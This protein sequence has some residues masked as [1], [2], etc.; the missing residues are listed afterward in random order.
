MSLGVI[1]C[2]KMA[3]ALVA[4]GVRAGAIEAAG[5]LGYDPL[6]G[7]L[8][9]FGRATGARAADSL[10]AL[11]AASERLLLCVRPQDVPAVLGDLG[12]LAT[13]PV[14]LISIAAGITTNTLE[15]GLPRGSR[16]IR[17]MPNTPALVDQGAAAYCAGRHA[18][19]ADLAFA[20]RLLGSIGMAIEVPET[21]MDAVTGL[22][23]SGPAFVFL[24]IEALADG[25]VSCGLSRTQALQLAAQTV[26]GAAA[27][28]LKTGQHPALLRDQVASPGGT[29]I[30]GLAEL[31]RHR[32]RA[33]L[34]DAVRAAARRS[35]ELGGA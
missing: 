17:C 14:A 33:A 2:G 7:A 3:T 23:G 21:L 22:S 9:A 18:T 5:V 8:E 29:T 13:A 27:M 24:I 28:V 32:L 15:D 31:E 35:A 16:V 34:L 1:G 20:Q 19:A 30:A 4:G 6:G 26:Y 11:V 12:T 25:G 10:A